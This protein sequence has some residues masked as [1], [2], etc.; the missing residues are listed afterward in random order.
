MRVNNIA[1]RSTTS[2]APLSVLGIKRTPDFRWTESRRD[3]LPV[4]K[5]ACTV[6]AIL[7][8]VL[9]MS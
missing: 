2:V 9:G 1:V 3:F 7:L 8:S 5:N 4:E 6:F